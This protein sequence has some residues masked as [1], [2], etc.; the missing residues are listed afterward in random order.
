MA[1]AACTFNAVAVST[2]ITTVV[3]PG[4]NPIIAGTAASALPSREY[5]GDVVARRSTVSARI[6][7]TPWSDGSSAN[8]NGGSNHRTAM[9]SAQLV[10]VN[11]IAAVRGWLPRA[12][13]K[14]PFRFWL[15]ILG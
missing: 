4:S 6:Y 5:A 1:V 10:A 9:K 15:R 2:T 3:R 12:H 14:A 11:V 13:R 8:T 7:V